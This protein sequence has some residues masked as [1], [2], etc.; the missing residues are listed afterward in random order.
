M[1]MHYFP[2]P[3][4][5]ILMDYLSKNMVAVQIQIEEHRHFSWWCSRAWKQWQA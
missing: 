3:E 5:Q 1:N 4:Q 2:D